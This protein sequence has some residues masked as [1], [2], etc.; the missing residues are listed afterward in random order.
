[1]SFQIQKAVRKQVKFKMALTAPSGGGKT[2][3]A[4]KIAKGMQESMAAKGDQTK[5]G[6]IDTE[7]GSASLYADT[8]GMPEF[9]TIDLSPPYLT[10]RFIDATKALIDA[11]CG[12]IV[13]DSMSHQW[14]GEGG[15]LDR[16]EKLD[17]RPGSNSWANWA[18]F[19]PEHEQ[20]KSFIQQCPA[21]VV[22]CL[23]SK[24]EY[25]QTEENGKKKIQKLGA[26]PVQRDGMEFEFS[27]V[28]DLAMNHSADVSKDRTGL[29]DGQI[30]TPSEATGKKII[31][32]LSSGTKQ[33]IIP[34]QTQVTVEIRGSETTGFVFPTGKLRGE[35]VLSVTTA[36]LQHYMSAMVDTLYSAGMTA[37]RLTGEKKDIFQAVETELANR[38]RQTEQ[39]EF[40]KF[41]G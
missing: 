28:L 8:P 9:F 14:M 17:A 26:A 6:F 39:S 40:D 12:I 20:F 34:E 35:N 24:Q 15:I 27:L 13:L 37:D 3:S 25:T 33:E 4:L 11:G 18:K 32:W 5:I 30:F 19:T 29:F 1:M 16:K 38:T 36:N 10:T 41:P 2:Y 31:D 22:A 21:H 23:R 7:N